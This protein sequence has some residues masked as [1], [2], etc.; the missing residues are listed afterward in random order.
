MN[1]IKYFFFEHSEHVAIDLKTFFWKGVKT[2]IFLGGK[3]Q[4]H[5]LKSQKTKKSYLSVP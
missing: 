3:K 5:Q 4:K 2:R 1:L